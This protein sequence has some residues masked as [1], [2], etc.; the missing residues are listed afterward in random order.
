LEALVKDTTPMEIVQGLKAALDE[1]KAIETLF[2]NP[3]RAVVIMEEEGMIEKKR[4]DYYKK[5]PDVLADDTRKGV[6]F[7]FVSLAIAGGYM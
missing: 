3:E 2:A 6:Y 5:N 4:V 1:L 7:A